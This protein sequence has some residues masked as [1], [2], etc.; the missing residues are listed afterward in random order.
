MHETI[1]CVSSTSAARAASR[2]SQHRL[3]GGAK[4]GTT[5]ERPDLGRQAFCPGR[6]PSGSAARDR[7]ISTA[8]V[9]ALADRR[10]RTCR[11]VRPA[12]SDNTPPDPRWPR[13]VLNSFRGGTGLDCALR[14]TT[15]RASLRC[16]RDIAAQ[17][18]A[19]HRRSAWERE[20]DLARDSNAG[21]CG[22]GAFAV[23][24][25]AHVTAAGPA[26]R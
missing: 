1:S 20:P 21:P 6:S 18:R 11:G 10:H 7:G 24:R 4:F 8:T 13:A 15:H 26:V 19:R 17:V 5:G 22:P 14:L 16:M 2:R 12:R 25:C 9:A 23:P 3:H